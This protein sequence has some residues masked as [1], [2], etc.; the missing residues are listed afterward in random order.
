MNMHRLGAYI[1][2]LASLLWFVVAM[3][4]VNRRSI[5]VPLGVVFFILGIVNLKRAARENRN[6]R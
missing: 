2:F 3:I 5:S 1:F 6:G 4:N